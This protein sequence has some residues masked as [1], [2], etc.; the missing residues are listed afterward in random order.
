MTTYSLKNKLKFVNPNYCV[1]LKRFK[2]KD[3]SYENVTISRKS[4]YKIS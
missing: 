3:M 4:T 1:R 2:Y